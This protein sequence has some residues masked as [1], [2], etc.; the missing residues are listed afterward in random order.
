MMR[1]SLLH[2]HKNPATERTFLFNYPLSDLIGKYW[3]KNYGNFIE[4]YLVS[5][6]IVALRYFLS[7]K[8]SLKITGKIQPLIIHLNIFHIHTFCIH[9]K[10]TNPTN[11][12]QNNVWH[13]L[14]CA[15]CET[16]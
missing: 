6:R 16:S 10:F 8:Y 14:N 11:V 7:L 4:P 3:K 9:K 5:N 15:I 13:S 2:L 12:I 1:V